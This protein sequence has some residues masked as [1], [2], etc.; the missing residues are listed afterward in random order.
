MTLD[1]VSPSARAVRALTIAC[2]WILS[3]IPACSRANGAA[4]TSRVP[5]VQVTLGD[6]VAD[7]VRRSTYDLSS[8]VRPSSGIE[9]V[10]VTEPVS[11]AYSGVGRSVVFPEGR[12][13]SLD[14]D[15]GAVVG[16]TTSPHMQALP[17]R[18]A[19]ALARD[20]GSLLERHGWSPDARSGAAYD[21]AEHA[22]RADETGF[23]EDE[24]GRWRAGGD[25][26]VVR[27]RQVRSVSDAADGRRYLVSVEFENPQVLQDHARIGG[28]LR[29]Q[30]SA[31]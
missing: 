1:A 19:I 10:A 4:V 6:D 22:A 9:L 7:V 11:L 14:T 24:V 15:A 27:I 12:F 3:T 18:D 16:V 21:A 8:K 28:R 17:L 30:Q 29:E 26:A 23:F 13:V 20:L 25:A 5:T 2:V 31:P